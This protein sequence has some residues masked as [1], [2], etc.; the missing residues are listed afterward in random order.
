[1]HIPCK[2]D[3]NGHRKEIKKSNSI[4]LKCAVLANTAFTSA[5]FIL[6]P[7]ISLF[8]VAPTK[9]GSSLI[10]CLILKLTTGPIINALLSLQVSFGLTHTI[11]QLDVRRAMV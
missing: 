1:M 4:L 7:S 9:T 6:P 11:I 8:L 3:S 10:T 5:L 2:G